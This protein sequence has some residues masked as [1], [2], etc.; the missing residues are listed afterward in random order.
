MCLANLDELRSPFESVYF[1][2][3]KLLYLLRR[4]LLSFT[5][6]HSNS[7][8]SS[9]IEISVI[10]FSFIIW[11]WTSK[12]ERSSTASR[13]L[14]MYSTTSWIDKKVLVQ[15][16]TLKSDQEEISFHQFSAHLVNQPRS[17]N[18]GKFEAVWN[19]GKFS[20]RGRTAAVRIEGR[21]CIAN[22]QESYSNEDSC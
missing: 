22:A 18:F 11:M 16:R 19:W 2:T 9:V 14:W 20:V 8:S 17:T 1:A 7:F 6:I 15:R 3:S 4:F 13:L 21:H 5:V 12:S 10:P